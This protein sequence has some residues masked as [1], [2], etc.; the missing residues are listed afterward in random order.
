MSGYTTSA[1]I[2]MQNETG[3]DGLLVTHN[4]EYVESQLSLKYRK[5]DNAEWLSLSGEVSSNLAYGENAD[6]DITVQTSD[7][8]GDEYFGEINITSNSQSVVT[9]PV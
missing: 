2:G 5:S 3:L 6:L 1:T 4:D 7:L 8:I 9:I